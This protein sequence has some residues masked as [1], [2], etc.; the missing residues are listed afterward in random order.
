[1]IGS[2]TDMQGTFAIDESEQDWSWFF[3]DSLKRFF[4]LALGANQHPGMLDRLD[5]LELD[6]TGPGHRID[7]LAGCVG[8]KMHVTNRH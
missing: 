5:A 3:R 1:M 4:D 7:R 2:R 8:N 6:R